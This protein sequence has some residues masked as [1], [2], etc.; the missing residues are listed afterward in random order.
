MFKFEASP[1]KK[2]RILISKI[3]KIKQNLDADVFDL[4]GHL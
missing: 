1:L 4:E 3:I 2:L